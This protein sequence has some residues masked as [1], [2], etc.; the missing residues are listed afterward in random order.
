MQD[1]ASVNSLA[2]KTVKTVYPKIFDIGCFSNTI[3]QVGEH[4][5]IPI[6]TEFVANWLLLFSHS[7]K[8]KFLW[9]EQMGQAMASYSATRW[10]SKWE[11]MKQIMTQ[12]GDIE[13]FLKSST[14]VGPSSRQKLLAI[15]SNAEK[16][17]HLKLELASVID[18]GEVFVKATYNL[19]GDGPLAFTC[20][21]E[22]QRVVAAIRGAH[23]PNTKA[24][25]RDIS[26]R[27]LCSAATSSLC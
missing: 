16:L 20:Y 19:E 25:I 2:M 12:F 11:L 3:D 14:D 15:L 10:W 24:V 6:L 9:K 17:K 26:T 21:E 23:T 4:F 5:N 18:W 27:K 8:A 13:P 7:Y 22:V 1:R